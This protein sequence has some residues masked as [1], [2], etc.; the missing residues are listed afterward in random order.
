MRSSLPRYTSPCSNSLLTHNSAIL[1]LPPTPALMHKTTTLLL[2]ANIVTHPPSRSHAQIFLTRNTRTSC[3]FFAIALASLHQL[4]LHL[5][6]S[7]IDYLFRA[8]QV[9]L[10]AHCMC[11]VCE[12]AP[13]IRVV[14]GAFVPAKKHIGMCVY[15]G[16]VAVWRF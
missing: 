7:A 12:R 16:A 11:D 9:A 14:L 3:P 4:H 10:P 6:F 15:W 8:E 1:T 2:T 5:L 13:S